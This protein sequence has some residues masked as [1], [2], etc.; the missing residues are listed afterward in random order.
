MPEYSGGG[1]NKA[2]APDCIFDCIEVSTTLKIRPMK[3]ADWFEIPNPDGSKRL[4]GRFAKAI[5]K[6]AGTVTAYCDGSAWPGRDAMADIARE[7]NNEV[8][9]NDFVQPQIEAAE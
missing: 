1:I 2:T 8:T 7:T 6:T 9:A 4:K 5:G 3:L